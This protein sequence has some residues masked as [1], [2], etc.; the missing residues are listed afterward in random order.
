MLLFERAITCF[1]L[2]EENQCTARPILDV[3]D[4]S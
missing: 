3:S 2:R 4:D 1:L